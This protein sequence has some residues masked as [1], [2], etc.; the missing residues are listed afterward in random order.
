MCIGVTAL[1]VGWGAAAAETAIAGGI[2]GMLVDS[3]AGATVQ[4]RQWC[5]QCGKPTERLLHSCGTTTE[6]RGGFHWVD[7]DAVNAI[8]SITGA[9]VGAILFW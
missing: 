1:V 3:L 4:R 2:A 9:V 7:N 5:E 8:S 6:T